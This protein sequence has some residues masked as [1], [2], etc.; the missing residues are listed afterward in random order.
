MED[1]LS[2]DKNEENL[3]KAKEEE[4]K[5]YIPPT[6]SSICWALYSSEDTF[7][8]SMD[9]Y[10][11]GYLYECR[12]VNDTKNNKSDKLGEAFRAKPVFKSDL[13]HNED[14]PLTCIINE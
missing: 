2:D 1:P 7:W 13:T 3:E 4:W 5:P 10:D 14:I 12:F 9:D 8:L 11:A 6:P